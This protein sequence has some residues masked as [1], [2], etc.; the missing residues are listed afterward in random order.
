MASRSQILVTLGQTPANA[1]I[2]RQI[3]AE[4]QLPEQVLDNRGVTFR[5]AR[6]SIVR[7]P[8]VSLYTAP[9]SDRC[10]NKTKWLCGPEDVRLPSSVQHDQS[11]PWHCGDPSGS[12]GPHFVVALA[13]LCSPLPARP[14]FFAPSVFRAQAPLFPHFALR[15]WLAL[16]RASTSASR[17]HLRLRHVGP[18]KETSPTSCDADQLLADFGQHRP[19]FRHSCTSSASFGPKLA[20]GRGESRVEPALLHHFQKPQMAARCA[21]GGASSIRA[22]REVRRRGWGVFRRRVSGRSGAAQATKLLRTNKNK[23]LSNREI[24]TAVKRAALAPANSRTALWKGRWGDDGYRGRG[25]GPRDARLGGGGWGWGLRACGARQTAALIRACVT[26]CRHIRL[27]H[28]PT[29]SS[30]P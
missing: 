14:L 26:S 28:R 18:P 16:N 10:H 13:N 9:G 12:A 25:V 5:G 7:Q 19:G 2:L 8:S 11:A 1:T 21:F 17:P 23:T 4:T 3:L 24:E 15:L 29:I 20:K 22:W 30:T 6:R 27:L